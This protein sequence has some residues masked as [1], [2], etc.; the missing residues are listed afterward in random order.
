MEIGE[1]L[2]LARKV[3]RLS[4]RDVERETGV[5]N[6]YLSQLETGKIKDPSFRVMMT[7]IKFYNL[8]VD[9]FI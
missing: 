8:S 7:L 9:D 6:S 4:L 3:L 2:R 1:K 5:S